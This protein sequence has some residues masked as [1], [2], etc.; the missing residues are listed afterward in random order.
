MTTTT[1]MMM[2][3]ACVGVVNFAFVYYCRRRRRRCCCLV[4]H[5]GLSGGVGVSPMSKSANQYKHHNLYSFVSQ[6]FFVFF[7][8]EK[9]VSPSV[10]T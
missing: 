9:K 2:I 3:V 8:G 10:L 1:M 4:L 5:S 6:F 7:F